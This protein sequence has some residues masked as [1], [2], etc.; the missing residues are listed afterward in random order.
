MQSAGGIVGL[1]GMYSINND[2]LESLTEYSDQLE[3]LQD[4]AN[5][6]YNWQRNNIAQQAIMDATDALKIAQLLTNT[7]NEYIEQ[8]RNAR[9]ENNK[10]TGHDYYDP[11]RYTSIAGTISDTIGSIFNNNGESVFDRIGNFLGLGE[12]ETISD[13][14]GSIFGGSGTSLSISDTFGTAGTDAATAFGNGFSSTLSDTTPLVNVD[15]ISGI[16]NDTLGKYTD[17][18]KTASDLPDDVRYPVISPV[19]DDSE[20]K[21]EAVAL[22]NW[23]NG[24]TYDQFAVDTGKSM[25]VREESEGDAVTDGNVSISYT[26]INNSPKEL[27]PIEVYRDT[28]NLLRGSGKFALS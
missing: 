4:Y 17:A 16:N 5:I 19:L 21:D 11:D 25:L 20:F 26:Q 27:S 15:D 28:K 23:W 12:G 1:G 6:G 9:A 18:L 22:V 8:R 3:E 7:Q 2:T 10:D 13:K 24:K 14:I